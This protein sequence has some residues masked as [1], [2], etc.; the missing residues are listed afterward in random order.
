MTEVLLMIPADMRWML[1]ALLVG[2]L[3]L[4]AISQLIR[5]GDTFDD[6]MKL[7]D[8]YLREMEEKWRK[9]QE[10]NDDENSS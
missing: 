7:R 2:V 9:E 5:D 1:V 4:Y 3:F 8:D 6:Y 10:E